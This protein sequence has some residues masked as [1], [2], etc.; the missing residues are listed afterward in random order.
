MGRILRNVGKKNPWLV[1]RSK[2]ALNA[3]LLIKIALVSVVLL[4]FLLPRMH[5]RYFF[6]ADIFSIIFAFY[7]PRY[8]YLPVLMQLISFFSYQPFLFEKPVN[9]TLLTFGMLTVILISG[10]ALVKDLYFTKKLAPKI[11]L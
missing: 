8:F 2:K 5:E 4:P 6:A 9:F 11:H 3:D 1:W 7:F 10:H